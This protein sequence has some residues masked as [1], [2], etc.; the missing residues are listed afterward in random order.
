MLDAL[1]DHWPEYLMEAVCLGLFMVSAFTF[2]TLMEHPA[3]LVHQAI[4]NPMLRR[5]LMGLAMGSTAI[6]IIYSPW[7]KQSGAH[8]NPS[9]TLTFFRL[10]KIATGDAGLYVFSQFV[11]GSAGALLASALLSEWVSHPSVNYVVTMPGNAGVAVACLAEVAISFVLMTVILHVSN[12]PRLH[13]FTGL[14]AGAL[15]ATYITFEAPI[16]GMSMNPA[17]SFASAVAAQHWT[18]L[19]IYFT[20]PLIGMFSAAEVY[21]R[22]RGREKIVCAKLH[23]ENDKRCIFCGKPAGKLQ[24]ENIPVIPNK[25]SRAS[26]P[27]LAAQR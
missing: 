23:H 3:S 10:G 14:C 8:I 1:K 24:S 5:F 11:G 19:W 27:K 12:N 21:V 9:T 20:A 22:S 7:G 26:A 15:V 4:P 13:K 25:V 16:S 17:R 18:V 6:A 2:G